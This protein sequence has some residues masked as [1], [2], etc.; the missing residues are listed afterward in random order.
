[1]LVPLH[2][3][4][5]GAIRIVLIRRAEA[6]I[7]GSQIAFPGGR[8]EP[9]DQTALATALREAE[10]EIGLDPAA[11]TFLAELPAVETLTS[12]HRIMPFLARIAPPARW[13]PAAAEVAE[14]IDARLD[15]LLRPEARGESVEHFPTWPAPRAVPFFRVGPHRLWGA[16]FRILEPV[17]PRIA[18]GEWPV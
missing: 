9:G 12:N 11:A 18:A 1:M 10:E 15:D 4:R 8:R 6:G 2:R 5:D 16:T 14:V 7:H 17:L 13:R 3:D